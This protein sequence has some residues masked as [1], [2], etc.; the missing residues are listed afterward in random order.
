MKQWISRI[1]AAAMV[2]SLLSVSAFAAERTIY[3]SGYGDTYSVVEVPEDESELCITGDLEDYGKVTLSDLSYDDATYTAPV[4]YSDGP[5]TITITGGLDKGEPLSGTDPDGSSWIKMALLSA[6]VDTLTFDAE[7]RTY[8]LEQENALYFDGEFAYDNDDGSEIGTHVMSIQEKIEGEQNEVYY[9]G[10]IYNGATVTLTE[11]GIYQ[12]GVNYEA[13]EGACV[14]YF[15]I[16]Q[17]AP[18]DEEAPAEETPAEPETPS[19][20]TPA[21]PTEDVVMPTNQALSVNGEAVTGAQVYNING[22]NYFKLRDVA[23]L[24][25][26]TGSQFA[27]EY[28]AAARQIVLTTGE[29]YT[30][31]GSELTAGEDQSATAVRSNQSLTIDGESASLTAYNIGGNNY[32]MLRDLGEALGFEVDYDAATRTMIMNSA[33]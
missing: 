28:D 4:Y 29:A 25:N 13:I 21:E 18:G 11:P 1:L 6:Y 33:A 2:V 27:L 10:Y 9:Y 26:G 5:V 7:T 14:A 19:E 20:E 30:P 8:I 22:S 16:G 12:V 3:L 31:D 32:F 15:W 23:A 17:R 24:L